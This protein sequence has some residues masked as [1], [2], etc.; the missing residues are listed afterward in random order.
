MTCKREAGLKVGFKAACTC[1]TPMG[2]LTFRSVALTSQPIR[3]VE[4]CNVS[5][6]TISTHFEISQ[7]ISP[8]YV[9]FSL[10]AV[11]FSATLGHC[12]VQHNLLG[13][14]LKTIFRGGIT[15]SDARTREILDSVNCSM[16]LMKMLW[17]NFGYNY[18]DSTESVELSSAFSFVG[19]RNLCFS[20]C[21]FSLHF[22][23]ITA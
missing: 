9:V 20:D 3:Q 22:G 23:D 11:Q 5:H 12:T 7:L 8:C 14:F 18:T 21:N 19:L 10:K 1:T 4:D 17:Y 16:F 15:F 13:V 6:Q 2:R